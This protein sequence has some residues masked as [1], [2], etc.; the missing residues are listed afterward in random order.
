MAA[1]PRSLR[2]LVTLAFVAFAA[3]VLPACATYRD[4]LARGQRAFEQN[5]HERALAIFRNLESG[6][7]HLTPEER[8]RYAYLRGMTDYRIGYQIDARY[9]LGLA[10]AL[11]DDHQGALPSD[12]HS[13]MKEALGELNGMVWEKGYGSLSNVLKHVEEEPKDSSDA[14][15]AKEPKEAKEDEEKEEKAPKAAP[16]PPE[17][18]PAPPPPKKRRKPKPKADDEP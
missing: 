11:E 9:W 18:T 10:K 6:L 2:S 14:K 13:R 3:A 8:A 15:E 1:C 5:A 12:W 17:P 7:S 4:D 16:A